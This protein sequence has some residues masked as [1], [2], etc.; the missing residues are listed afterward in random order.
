MSR[1]GARKSRL[2]EAFLDAKERLD[3]ELLLDGTDS[4][5]PGT[6]NMKRF[7]VVLSSETSNTS[8]GLEVIAES[9][10]VRK[11]VTQV[12]AVPDPS[13]PKQNRLLAVEVVRIEEGGRI[14]QDGRVKVG[15]QITDINDRPVYQV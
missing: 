4:S 3:E 10:P 12:S 8:T 7:K 5:V 14:A 13:D 15:D 2:T 1:T 6:S 9:L 11:F